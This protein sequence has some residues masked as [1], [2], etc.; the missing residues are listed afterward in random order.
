MSLARDPGNGAVIGTT[1]GNVTD[2][3]TDDEYGQLHEYT[4]RFGSTVLYS[5]TFEHD[6]LGRLSSKTETVEGETHTTVYTYDGAGRLEDVT[7]DGSLTAHYEYDTAGNRLSRA[8]DSATDIGTYEGDRLLSCGGSTFTYTA[9]G[10]RWTKT[11]TATGETTTYGYDDLGN[12]VRVDLPD[13]RRGEYIVDAA[14]RRIGKKIDGALVQGFLWGADG[15]IAAE[16]DGTGGV[17]S[18]FV[19]AS[20]DSAPDFLVKGGRTYRLVKDL[21]GS[22]RLVVDASSGAV[23]Q[24][25]DYDEFGGVVSQTGNGFQPFG[26]AGALRDSVDLPPL[27]GGRAYDAASA[28]FLQGP[29]LQLLSAERLRTDAVSR[30]AIYANMERAT[31]SLPPAQRATASVSRY[32]RWPLPPVGRTLARLLRWEVGAHPS[33]T[34]G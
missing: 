9:K 10:E 19:Y 29:P 6:A 26:F 15:R 7:R 31:R 30:A 8:T 16:L 24:R 28:V 34:D 4:A 2:S 3:R 27:V 22:P 23:A 11:D 32:P 1:L 20:E 25:I 5:V 12:L 18:R 14:N 13:G 33:G 17:V 21:L